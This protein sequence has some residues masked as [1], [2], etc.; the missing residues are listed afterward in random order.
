MKLVAPAAVAAVMTVGWTQ[1]VPVAHVDVNGF[2]YSAG[3][4]GE[5]AVDSVCRVDEKHVTCWKPDGTPNAE[6]S[7]RMNAERV[8]LGDLPK[9]STSRLALLMHCDAPKGQPF[10]N[11]GIGATEQKN[12]PGPFM[13]SSS[14]SVKNPKQL[15]RIELGCWI[16]EDAQ[17]KPI[18]A[19]IRFSALLAD[20]RLPV[21]AGVPVR[22]ANVTL[23]FDRYEVQRKP[24]SKPTCVETVLFP[25]GFY[26]NDLSFSPKFVDKHGREVPQA[27]ESQEGHSN[28]NERSFQAAWSMKTS[29][30]E[31]VAA[32][33][34]H[35][36]AARIVVFHGI[37]LKPKG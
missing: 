20:R 21:G 9:G 8:I 17:L 35:P 32:V 4:S 24:K 3:A 30:P 10:V 33:D 15:L 28:G 13:A 36:S 31:K 25:D 19:H 11:A 5:A 2:H 34:L 1:T 14:P 16:P 22:V 37:A 7:K 6:L 12:V 26:G 29:E 18:D 23:K 27:D